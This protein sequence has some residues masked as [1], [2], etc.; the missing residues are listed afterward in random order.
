M[1]LIPFALLAFLSVLIA[2]C[3]DKQEAAPDTDPK[4]SSQGTNNNSPASADPGATAK[5][6]PRVNTAKRNKELLRA[7]SLDQADQAVAAIEAGATPAAKNRDGLP[8]LFIAAEK[9][10]TAVVKALLKAGADPNAAIGMSF[11]ED[12][13]GYRGT[14]DG[15]VLGYAAAKGNQLV[16]MDL[17]AAGADVNGAGPDGTTPLMMA[18]DTGKLQAVRWLLEKGADPNQQNKHGGTALAMAQL[19]FSP[20]AQ[21]QQIIELLKSKMTE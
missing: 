18:A 15:T 3:K 20:D 2:S 16:M 19:M 4:T 11:N 21:R 9:G 7:L 14:K 10:D 1:K 17:V 13:V 5:P 8:V 12:G 6:K